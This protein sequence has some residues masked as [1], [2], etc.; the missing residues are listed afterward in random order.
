MR[1][2]QALA[3]AGLTLLACAAPSAASIHGPMYCWES[4]LEFPVPCDPDEEDEAAVVPPAGV[5]LLGP[6]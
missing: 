1:V 4:D 3:L 5:A 2:L 6:S